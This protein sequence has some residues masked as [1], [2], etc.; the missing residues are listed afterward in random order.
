MH[1]ADP[2]RCQGPSNKS[3]LNPLLLTQERNEGFS[4]IAEHLP[5]EWAKIVVLGHSDKGGRQAASWPVAS[6]LF[7][8][9]VLLTLVGS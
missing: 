9:C 4:D 8:L 2:R 7:S 3:I 5:S 1:S 6:S